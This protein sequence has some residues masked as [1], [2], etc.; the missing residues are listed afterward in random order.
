M[1]KEVKLTLLIV[2]FALAFLALAFWV[3]YRPLKRLIVSKNKK[4]HFFRKIIK[5]ARDG[6]F[7]LV[8]S[9]RFETD[10]IES[11]RIDHLLAGNKFIYV[12]TDVYAPGELLIEKEKTD[13]AYFPHRGQKTLIPNPLIQNRKSVQHLAYRCGIDRSFLVGIVLL[14]EE[15]SV[16]PYV[17]AEGDSILAPISEVGKIIDSFESREIDAFKEGE[18]QQT[19]RD[20][21][22][23]G[24]K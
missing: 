10:G 7:Y 13:W 12:I 9:L 21:S 22:I 20:L 5:V 18:L 19:I 6:D 2:I 16:N 14:D 3:L 8:N 17:N 4:E 23:I 24:K 11:A 1:P 15:C